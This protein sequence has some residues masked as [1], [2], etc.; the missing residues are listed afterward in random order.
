MFILTLYLMFVSI[1]D[2]LVEQLGSSSFDKRN[3]AQRALEDLGG[4]AQPALLRG[5]NS[6]DAEIRRRSEEATC[7]LENFGFA[8]MPRIDCFPEANTG[9]EIVQRNA[10]VRGSIEAAVDEVGRH[11]RPSVDWL[12][13]RATVY[14]TRELLKQGCSR[15]EIRKLLLE[16]R[17]IE[18]ERSRNGDAAR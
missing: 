6:N 3:T 17:R 1:T 7:K 15:S 4:F 5:L 18:K 9:D 8:R 13:R 11:T 10:I 2:T 16:M 14:M 12:Q